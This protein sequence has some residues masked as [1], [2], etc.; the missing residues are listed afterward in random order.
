VPSLSLTLQNAPSGGRCGFL[1]AAIVRTFSAS[2]PR[3]LREHIHEYVA[4]QQFLSRFGKRSGSHD[5]SHVLLYVI[6]FISLN[7]RH[8]SSAFLV[9]VLERMK[10]VAKLHLTVYSHCEVFNPASNETGLSHRTTLPAD[11]ELTDVGR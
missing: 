4:L 6:E 10:K 5:T 11:S 7:P 8:L 9:P 2:G 3:R 1:D